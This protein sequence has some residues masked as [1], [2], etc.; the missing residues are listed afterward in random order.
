MLHGRE[1]CEWIVKTLNG[2]EPAAIWGLS[3]GDVAWW[4]YDALARELK[5]RMK[6][7]GPNAPDYLRWLKFLADTSGLH[8]EDRDE[9]WPLFD[10][11]CRNSPH[12]LVQHWWEPA[13]RF[14]LQ[15][16]KAQGVTI[17]SEGFGYARSRH[18]K[19]D[20]NAVYRLMDHGLWWPLR[21]GKRLAI[22]SGHA[23]AFAARLMAPDFVRA[24]GGTEITWNIETKVKCAP[25]HEAKRRDMPDMQNELFTSQWDL[26]PCSAG[27]LSAILADSSNKAGRFSLD[28]GSLDLKFL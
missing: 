12:W 22:V 24:N 13:E 5:E 14:T 7:E 26:L 19:I 27:S 11:A 6:A 10:Q 21:E 16:L 17:D 9:L 2:P 1:A 23:D 20:C 28:I 8:D 18:R 15:A 4:C 25:V 3:D